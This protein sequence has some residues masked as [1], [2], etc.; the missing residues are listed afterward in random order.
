MKKS[1]KKILAVVGASLA[2]LSF[3]SCHDDIY[4]LIEK[5]VQIDQSGFNG[6]ISN[7]VHYGDYI[8]TC[9]GKIWAKTNQ[10]SNFTK[11]MNGQWFLINPPS[12]ELSDE[13]V[14]D[15]TYFLA[16]DNQYLYALTYSWY[17]NEDG[18]N[19]PKLANIYVTDDK[20]PIDGLLWK[21]VD[22]LSSGF[23]SL[24]GVQKLIFDNKYRKITENENLSLT[25]DFSERRAYAKLLTPSGYKIY[26][27]NGEKTPLPLTDEII[28]PP[29]LEPTVINGCYFNGR[30]YLSA[31]YA[32]TANDNYLY[33]AQ[34]YTYGNYGNIST[35][36][37]IYYLGKTT[38]DVGFLNTN[39]SILSMAVANDC[40]LMGTTS[41]LARILL[42]PATKKPAFGVKF[43]S[44]GGSIISE[45][46]Y[47]V[48]ILDP[49]KNEDSAVN[50][51]D[52]YAASTI[53]GSISSSSDSIEN[54]GLYAF[55][56]GRFFNQTSGG[57]NRD[58]N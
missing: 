51:T 7:I 3:V 23:T 43:N 16:S 13:K 54:V 14:R 21:K 28:L 42:D 40:I 46:V 57:W 34:T 22:L 32:M 29:C 10:P 31:Y 11:R 15:V 48:F 26:R 30:T 37:S 1:I 56:P 2:L 9:N 35:G 5:E 38:D 36:S 55:Y 12:N 49:S 18:A 27:L 47:M 33:Y 53:Y 8:F 50:G 39:S 17:E 6:D 52:E 44:N 4:S 41:G 20:N 58:G 24:Y 25:Y 19:K 45:Y